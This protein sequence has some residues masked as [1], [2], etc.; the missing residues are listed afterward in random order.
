MTEFETRIATAK[1]NIVAVLYT[2]P[3]GLEPVTFCSVVQERFHCAQGSGIYATMAFLPLMSP[4]PD[5]E[6]FFNLAFVKSLKPL[7]LL[8]S[9]TPTLG[10]TLSLTPLSLAKPQTSALPC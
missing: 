4:E 1:K 5:L 9:L 10:K 3:T 7:S 6:K 8:K 2:T